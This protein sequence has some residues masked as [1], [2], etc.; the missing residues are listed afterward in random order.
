MEYKN[1][2]IESDND[3]D[4]SNQEI[5]NKKKTKKE[6]IEKKINDSNSSNP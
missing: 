6:V 4:S 3:S 5:K 1:N 2:L